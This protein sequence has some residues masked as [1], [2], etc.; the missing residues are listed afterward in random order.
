MKRTKKLA[1]ALLAAVML[2]A[3]LVGC[4]MTSTA[5]GNTSTATGDTATASG[6]GKLEE[7]MD[8]GYLIVGTGSTN[9]PWHFYGDD[10]KLCGFDVSMAKILAE[11]IF[12]DPEAVKFVEQS[13]DERVPNLVNGTVDICFQFM[14][15][16]A[17]RAQQIDFTVPYYTEGCEVL[18][19]SSGKYKSAD[20]LTTA[21][22]GGATATVAILQNSF[23]EDIVAT[24]LPD[25]KV[26]VD[27]YEDQALLYQALQSGRCDCAVC[28]MS[29]AN[30]QAVLD[31]NFIASGITGYPQNYGAGVQK[32]DQ[33]WLNYVNTVLIDAMTGATYQK[34][35]DAYQQWFGVK[36]DPPATGK[37]TMY[38]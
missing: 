36:L 37:P 7:I 4:G 1:A 22:K 10:G 16:N 26:K 20:E 29:N 24:L 13:S 8:R 31:S 11:S 14:T 3:T 19:Y 27:Q 28:D 15:I 25:Y 17:E 35:I 2:A 6:G 23:A 30:Y 33:E 9:A 5:G 21:L 34:Y 12:G 38:R 32:G 18:L